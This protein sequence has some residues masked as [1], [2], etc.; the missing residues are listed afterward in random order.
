MTLIGNSTICDYESI[1]NLVN[2][3]KND[4]FHTSITFA[5]TLFLSKKTHSYLTAI[6]DARMSLTLGTVIYGFTRFDTRL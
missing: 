2:V 1:Q 3:F 5:L 6:R 4:K